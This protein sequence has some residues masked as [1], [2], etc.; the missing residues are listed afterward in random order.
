MVG[1]AMMEHVQKHDTY[2]HHVCHRQEYG[3]KQRD[4][5]LTSSAFEDACVWQSHSNTLPTE[6]VF[7]CR[8]PKPPWCSFVGLRHTK[9]VCVPK[10]RGCRHFVVQSFVHAFTDRCRAGVPPP[11][12]C[13]ILNWV[14][15]AILLGFVAGCFKMR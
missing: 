6:L 3:R 1:S 11:A 8:R 15:L 14:T 2:E 4:T 10:S 7:L 13:F 12:Y 5:S 9:L